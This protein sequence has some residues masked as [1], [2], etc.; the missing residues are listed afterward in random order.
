MIG[1]MVQRTVCETKTIQIRYFGTDFKEIYMV[2]FYSER[3]TS[4]FE[5]FVSISLE[6]IPLQCMGYRG[7]E[8]WSEICLNDVPLMSLL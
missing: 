5:Y 1:R 2:E 6:D 7:C 8:N 4:S 3:S